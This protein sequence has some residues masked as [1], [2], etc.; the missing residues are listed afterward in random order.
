MSEE[1][2][3]A[4]PK[5]KGGKAKFLVVAVLSVAAGGALPMFVNVPALLGKTTEA[6]GDHADAKHAK[7][8]KKK[9]AHAEEKAAPVP[10]GEVTVNLADERMSRYLRLKIVLIVEEEAEATVTTMLEKK[11]AIMKGW[12]VSHLSGKTVQDVRYTAGVNRLK[13]EILERFDDILY[14]TG[15]GALKAVE[16]EECL[17]Q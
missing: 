2:A 5:K 3:P 7:P 9:A 4:A 13:R 10:F 14:P 6:E 8:A 1:A 12:L 16:F 11:K 15:H 17:V